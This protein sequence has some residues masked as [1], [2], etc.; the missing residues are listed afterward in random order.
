MD[1]NID[2]NFELKLTSGSASAEDAN[3]VLKNIILKE[4]FFFNKKAL[5]E[6]IY[7]R[8]K[9]DVGLDNFNLANQIKS[10]LLQFY[11]EKYTNVDKIKDLNVDVIVL[12]GNVS[13]YYRDDSTNKLIFGEEISRRL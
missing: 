11:N 5:L 4:E 7:N 1:L 6:E 10:N 9:Y 12:K 8:R 13:V 3:N 2:E